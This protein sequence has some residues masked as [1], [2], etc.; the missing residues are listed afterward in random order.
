MNGVKIEQLPLYRIIKPGGYVCIFG[1]P[2]TNHRMKSA[3]EDVGFNIV[4]EI[5]WVY[6]VLGSL[7][8]KI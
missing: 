7:R 6:L 4:E 2:K 3:F 5:D 8:I 1:H